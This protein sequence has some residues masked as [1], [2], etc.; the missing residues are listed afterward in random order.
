MI[1]PQVDPVTEPPPIPPPP[2]TRS[3]PPVPARPAPNRPPVIAGTKTRLTFT[4]YVPSSASMQ[5][6]EERAFTVLVNPAEVAHTRSIFYDKQRANGS[7]GSTLRF[8][9]M[10]HDKM[11]F[12]LVLDG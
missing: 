4:P 11:K 12:A 8:G 10:G 7:L 9:S 3:S 5:V 1:N 6:D 2:L